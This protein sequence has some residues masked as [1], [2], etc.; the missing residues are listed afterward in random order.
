MHSANEKSLPRREGSACATAE[1][2][3]LRHNEKI[4]ARIM[5]IAAAAVICPVVLVCG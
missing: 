5:T 2:G 4:S 3:L 1:I